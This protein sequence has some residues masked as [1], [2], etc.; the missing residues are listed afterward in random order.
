MP[1]FLGRCDCLSILFE[2]SLDSSCWMFKLANLLWPSPIVFMTYD[3]YNFFL[4]LNR[5][6]GQFED[7]PES[8]E[9]LNKAYSVYRCVCSCNIDERCYNALREINKLKKTAPE[10]YTR[11]A[12]KIS[13]IFGPQTS[14]KLG[15]ILFDI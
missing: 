12:A 4:E 10:P 1:D 14:V 8:V 7:L 11:F 2:Y 6:S 3:A 9:I 15:K 13:E 5:K